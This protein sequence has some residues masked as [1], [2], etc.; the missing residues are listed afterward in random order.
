MSKRLLLVFLA[1]AAAYAQAPKTPTFDSR[2]TVHAILREDIFA[3]F[4]AND[5][6]RQARGARNLE[7]LMAERPGDQAS[8]TAW[9]AA[10]AMNH[11]VDAHEAKR[12]AEFEGEYRRALDLYAEASKLGPDDGG[13]TAITGGSY[14]VFAD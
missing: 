10:L 6:D 2:L 4:M 14:S 8:L 13:V 7:T 5:K 3:G 1:G 12:E 9:K 11:A